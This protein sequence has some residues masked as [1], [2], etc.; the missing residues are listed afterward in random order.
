[1]SPLELLRPS[2]HV[3]FSLIAL[4]LTA[5]LISSLV[6]R[7]MGSARRRL[8]LLTGVIGVPVHEL[9][10][11]L[12][13]LGFGMRVREIALFT[14][15]PESPQLGYVNFAYSPRSLR[16]RVGLFFVGIA[17]LIAGAVISFGLLHATG[18]EPVAPD[19]LPTLSSLPRLAL[20]THE[21]AFSVFST[22]S[23]AD[24]GL[25]FV[26]I[27][28]ALHS[29]PSGADMRH[30]GIGLATGLSL[31]LVLLLPALAWLDSLGAEFQGL[32]RAGQWLQSAIIQSTLLM[33]WG[34]LALM[35]ILLPARAIAFTARQATV[36]Q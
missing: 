14:P 27:A 13:A 18:A 5:G 19:G 25:T 32:S 31:V 30:A 20:A 26:A 4:A 11:A 33:I 3:A 6:F 23:L 12:T 21:M 16:H 7:L 36:P 1:M 8:I 2:F 24:A 34:G 28:V 22:G 29:A 9:S 15:D 35:M 17:P 10:H